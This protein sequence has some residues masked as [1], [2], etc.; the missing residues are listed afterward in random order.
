MATLRVNGRDLYY[1]DHGP[2]NAPAIVL[3]P[4][5]FTNSSVYEPVIRM[6]ADDFRVIVY[7]HRGFGKSAGPANTSIEESAKD[8]AAL[9]ENLDIGPC[10]FVGNCL[11]AF[12]GLQLAVDRSDLLKGCVLMGVS[13]EAEKEESL[14]QMEEFFANARKNGMKDSAEGFAQ[15]WFGS[16]FRATKDPI[17]VTRRERWIH[18]V[19]KVK[20]E[21]VELA[22][23]LVHH[24]D[25][26]K[27]L[28]KITCD[29]LVMAG[30]EESPEAIESYKKLVKAVNGAEFKL[31]HHAGYALVIEQPEEVAENIRHFC[32]KVDRHVAYK[33]QHVSRDLGARA[34]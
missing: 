31:I 20:P 34:L 14:K 4:L 22:S 11:G 15:M 5:L 8:V 2:K 7:D 12:V 19:A 26:S 13:A 33:S 32:S 21:N 6:L 23:Q 24:K 10:H 3:S 9:I 30:D 16:S 25:L 17:Q 1:E 18:E 29:L 27:D 28:S